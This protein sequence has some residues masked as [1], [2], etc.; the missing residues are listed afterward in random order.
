MN[1]TH[2]LM[3]KLLW[4]RDCLWEFMVLIN[5]NKFDLCELCCWWT[6]YRIQN[7]GQYRILRTVPY[8]GPRHNTLDVT[9]SKQVHSTSIT[10]LSRTPRNN[11]LLDHSSSPFLFE[12]PPFH[13]TPSTPSLFDTLAL[14]DLP[15]FAITPSTIRV[16]IPL[17]TAYSHPPAQ[18]TMRRSNRILRQRLSARIAKAVSPADGPGWI[19]HYFDFQS[20]VKVGRSRDVSRRRREWDHACWNPNRSWRAAIWCANAHRAGTFS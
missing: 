19:Y 8:Y 16:H 9:S 7:S 18:S 6:W 11:F 12:S 4:A 3:Q 13:I 15:P 1:W 20:E 2:N 10:L 5:A 14:L 17:D